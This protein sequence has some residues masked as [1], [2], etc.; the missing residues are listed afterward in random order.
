MLEFL[1][2]ARYTQAS[3]L[4]D[5]GDTWAGH[6]RGPP[7]IVH[8]SA[9][10]G[11]TGTLCT[12]DIC[13]SRL[14]DSGT[15]DVRGTVKRIRSQRA[16]SI[17]MRDQYIFCHLALIEYALSRGLISAKPDLSGFQTSDSDTE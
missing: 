14:E 17:Q 12:L 8:C 4:A 6:P 9:G 11:R 1:A 3:L 13:I 7:I 16:H 2:K 10:I 15:V 5:L